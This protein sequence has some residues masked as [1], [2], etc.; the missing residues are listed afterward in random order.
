MHIAL[1]RPRNLGWLSKVSAVTDSKHSGVVPVTLC[2]AKIIST[3]DFTTSRFMD[4]KKEACTLT[5]LFRRLTELNTNTL[6]SLCHQTPGC[7]NICV[8]TSVI[9]MSAFEMVIT[10]ILAR[11]CRPMQENLFVHPVLPLFFLSLLGP[12]ATK[13]R[14][15]PHQYD[16]DSWHLYIQESHEQLVQV[17]GSFL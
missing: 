15:G 6:S 11:R 3:E 8:V 10:D 4:G 16:D 12:T 5:T 1:Q 2:Q 17:C 13:A 9:M 14:K 7:N